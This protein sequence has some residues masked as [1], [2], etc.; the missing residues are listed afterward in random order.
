VSNSKEI[1]AIHELLANH[2]R[3]L[4][5]ITNRD[6]DDVRYEKCYKRANIGDLDTLFEIYKILEQIDEPIENVIFDKDESL[7]T[8]F[9]LKGWENTVFFG[10]YRNYTSERVKVK[11]EKL[12]FA[13][14][15]KGAL[16]D[17]ID[18]D[19]YPESKRLYFGMNL[20]SDYMLFKKYKSDLKPWFLDCLLQEKK[21]RLKEEILEK[22]VELAKLEK[23]T[24]DV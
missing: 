3:G 16:K 10:I 22:N 13:L 6:C 15:K 17:D 7:R 11:L 18:K 21:Q 1:K 9:T 4:G 23:E 8:G 12:N 24:K 19:P 20:S 14:L 5:L 2:A